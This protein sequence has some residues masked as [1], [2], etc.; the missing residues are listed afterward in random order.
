MKSSLSKGRGQIVKEVGEWNG[1][2]FPV[3]LKQN[4]FD[5]STHVFLDSDLACFNREVPEDFWSDPKNN[6]YPNVHTYVRM[7]RNGET[8]AEAAAR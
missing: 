3:T 6:K 5:G 8:L 4:S 2:G 1:H 7:K